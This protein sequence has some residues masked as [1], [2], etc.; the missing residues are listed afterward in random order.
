[1]S[2]T[3]STVE[4]REEDDHYVAVDTLTG[5]TGS[6]KTRTLALAVL[7]GILANEGDEENAEL[8]AEFEGKIARSR[9][10]Y[11]EGKFSSLEEVRSRFDG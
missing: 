2:A 3:T 4:I 8:S 7:V 5:A 9:K 1:M 11:E 6:G 10:E